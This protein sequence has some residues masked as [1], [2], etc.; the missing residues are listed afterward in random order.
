[1]D[2]LPHTDQDRAQM[3]AE[4]GLSSVEDLFAVIPQDLKAQSW[5]LPSGLSEMEVMDRLGGL[6]EQNAHRLTCFLG[7][8]F[9]RS[10][11]PGRRGR[12]T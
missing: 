3:L 7:A 10:L 2:F 6:A 9:L 12:N 5:D 1:M 4:L 11:H 8:G